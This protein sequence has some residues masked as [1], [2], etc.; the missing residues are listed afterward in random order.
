MGLKFLK[1]GDLAHC[2]G[3][4]SFIVVLQLNLLESNSFVVDCVLSLE[5]NPISS[6]TDSFHAFIFLSAL[7]VNVLI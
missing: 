4:D 6:F 3:W 2:S 1:N 5:D 7:H